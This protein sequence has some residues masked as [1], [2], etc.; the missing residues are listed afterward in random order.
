M[1][2]YLPFTVL[3]PV[4]FSRIYSKILLVATVLTVYGIETCSKELKPLNFA[5]QQYLPFTVLKLN[6]LYFQIHS[7]VCCNSTYRLRYW[8]NTQENLFGS[9]AKVATVLTVYGIET[10]RSPLII[11]R[12]FIVATV[13]TVY[14]IETFKIDLIT[15]EEAIELQQY[16]PFTVLKLHLR[17]V[18]TNLL[19]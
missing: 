13:L 3:K 15:K 5:L 12:I 18:V 1:Q 11:N 8:N 10:K 2:Q 6:N 16:L 19:M 17:S 7:K 14:G 9:P 4:I